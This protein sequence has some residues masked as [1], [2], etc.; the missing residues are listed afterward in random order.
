MNSMPKDLIRFL[1]YIE[2]KGDC[3]AYQEQNP[4]RFDMDLA[5]RCIEELEAMQEEKVEALKKV[6]P[7]VPKYVTKKCPKITHKKNGEPTKHFQ[8]WARLLKEHGKPITTKELTY[9]KEYQEPNPNSNEQVKQWLYDLGWKPCTFKYLRDKDTGDERKIEQVRKDGEITQSVVNLKDKAPEVELLEGLSVIQHRLGI[10]R[11]FVDSAVEHNGKYYLK[12]EIGGLTNTFRF[13]HKRPIVNLPGVDKFYGKEIRSCLMADEGETFIGCDLVSLEDSTK[14]HFMQPL[15]PDYVEEMSQPGFDPHLSLALFAGEITQEQYDNF[16]KE[17]DHDLVAIRKAYKVTNYSATYGVGATKLAR[18]MGTSRSKAQ[19]LL[20]AYWEKNWSIT[21]IAKQQV[22]KQV[23]DY[24]WVWNPVS[25]FW[26]E[27]R[28]DKDIWSTVNQSTGVFIFDSWLA[29]A[30]LNGYMGQLSFHDET[31]ASV[32]DPKWAQ[33]A[34]EK[35]VD[36]LNQDLNLNVEIKIDTQ[37]GDTYG[38]VH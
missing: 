32:K 26:H 24:T 22:T 27:L 15:D 28:Y 25:G 17:R 4:I 16:D 7:K 33:E 23:G 18:E 20:D 6:M 21:K 5:K 13:K 37:T 35:A 31:G 19:A 8:E 11:G 14:R 3:A 38:D 1:R 29:R 12:A 30:R 34:L 10:F 2:F 36:R 9:V